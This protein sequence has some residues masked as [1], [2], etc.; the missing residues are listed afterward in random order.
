MTITAG[1]GTTPTLTHWTQILPEALQ[2]M[3]GRSPIIV[4]PTKFAGQPET[5]CQ[6]RGLLVYIRGDWRHADACLTCYELPAGGTCADRHVGCSWP[7]PVLCDQ[8]CGQPVSLASKGQGACD[9]CWN[10]DDRPD[11]DGRNLR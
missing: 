11:L 9:G 6:C 3:T 7:A 5:I 4:L 2:L 1:P 8:L 10:V